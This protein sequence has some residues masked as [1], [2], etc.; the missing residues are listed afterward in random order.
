MI[1]IMQNEINFYKELSMRN[2]NN[3]TFNQQL[4]NNNNNTIQLNNQLNTICDI[5]IKENKKLKKKLEIYKSKINT[6]QQNSSNK[7]FNFKKGD[8]GINFAEFETQINYQIDNFNNIISDY[9]SKL[10]EALN[11]ITELFENNNKEEAAK[12]LVEQINE[13][14]LE[15][16]KLISENGKT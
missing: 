5:F 11:K 2:N 9:N 4:Y 13:Y 8:V 6:I 10:S 16:Q 1:S 12:Y 3:Q 7:N 14:M 15:N